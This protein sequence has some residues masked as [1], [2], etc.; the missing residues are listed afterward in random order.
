[1]MRDAT[2]HND[3]ITARNVVIEPPMG[4]TCPAGEL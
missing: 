2:A 3:L 4:D 1:M